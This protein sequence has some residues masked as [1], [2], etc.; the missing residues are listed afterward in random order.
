M[1]IFYAFALAMMLLLSSVVVYAQSDNGNGVQGD[2][3]VDQTTT[4]ILDTTTTTILASASNG[5][6]CH[7]LYYFDNKNKNCDQKEFCGMFMYLGLRVFDTKEKCIEARDKVNKV[8]NDV[9]EIRNDTRD[10]MNEIRNG[11]IGARNETH[12]MINQIKDARQAARADIADAR[13]RFIQAKQYIIEKKKE[14]MDARQNF[15]GEKQKMIGDC[16]DASSETCKADRS[17]IIN[18]SKDYLIKLSDNIIEHLNKLK[19]AVQSNTNLSPDEVTS[20]V[21]DIDAKIAEIEQAKAAV[22]ESAT[23]EQVKAAAQ[24][25]KQD[26]QDIEKR[27]KLHSAKVVNANLGNVAA[28]LKQLGDKLNEKIADAKSKGVDTTKVEPMVTDFNSL[29]ASAQANYD[30]AQA[31]FAEA[32]SAN[33]V[34]SAKVQEGIKL[35]HTANDQLKQANSKLKEI[36]KELKAKNVDVNLETTTTTTMAA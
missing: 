29:V 32:K 14:A 6:N 22:S 34:D 11:V 21:S 26:W 4:T 36:V 7:T 35:F 33:A 8:R 19:A 1:K 10:R 27:I 24:T 20:I 23:K 30:Q 2:L 9:K 31:K 15:L 25:I 16:K 28:R 12:S 13:Q 18:D 5:K 17:N 3:G